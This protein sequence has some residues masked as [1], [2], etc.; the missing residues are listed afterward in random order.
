MHGLLWSPGKLFYG[1][2][3]FVKQGETDLKIRRAQLLERKVLRLSCLV[4]FDCLVF[5][6]SCSQGILD[7]VSFSFS[8]Y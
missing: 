4:G 7:F 8:I 2:P 5:Y 6:L 1:P 3:L